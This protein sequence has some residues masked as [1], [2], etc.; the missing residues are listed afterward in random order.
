VCFYFYNLFSYIG[1]LKINKYKFELVLKLELS[2]FS[3]SIPCI[4]FLISGPIPAH[5]SEHISESKAHN[6]N[7]KKPVVTSDTRDM[8]A[9]FYIPW[10]NKMDDLI[11]NDKRLWKN[12]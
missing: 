9:D 2:Q 7:Y 3:H 4:D 6:V 8:L 11:K 10:Q 5:N 1:G 12:L